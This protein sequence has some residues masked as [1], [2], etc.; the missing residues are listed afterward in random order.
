M[1]VRRVVAANAAN[2][3]LSGFVCKMAVFSNNGVIAQSKPASKTSVTPGVNASDLKG[4]TQPVSE[5]RLSQYAPMSTNPTPNNLRVDGVSLRKTAEISNV[6]TGLKISRGVTNEA[7][8]NFNALVEARCAITFKLA[9]PITP[10]TNYQSTVG[11]CDVRAKVNN[12]SNG[13]ER[14]VDPHTTMIG[15]A[16][17][18]I[19]L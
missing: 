10:T 9:E 7:S 18:S 5:L 4:M 17:F 16:S 11:I 3:G 2:R 1:I 14:K 15:S 19:R 8:A 13:N 6:K 12:P